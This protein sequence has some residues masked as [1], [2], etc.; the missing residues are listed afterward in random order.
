MFNVSILINK[1]NNILKN[2][3]N[4]YD[5]ITIFANYLNILKINFFIFKLRIFFNRIFNQKS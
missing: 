5:I 3:F 1:N 4:L 2:L